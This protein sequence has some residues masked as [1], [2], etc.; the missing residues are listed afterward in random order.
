MSIIF[1]DESKMSTEDLI[2]FKK[3]LTE[4]LYK[5]AYYNKDLNKIKEILRRLVGYLLMADKKK[6]FNY[7]DI[8]YELNILNILDGF[9][10]KKITQISFYILDCIYTLITNIQNTGFVF[11]IYSTKYATYIQG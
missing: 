9:L 10:N 4:L 1:P 2:L 6:L 3:E 7:F 8:F 11:Y 5:E